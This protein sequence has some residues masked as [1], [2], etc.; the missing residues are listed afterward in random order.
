[1]AVC[2]DVDSAGLLHANATPVDSCPSY[3]LVDASTY[4]NLPTIQDLFAVPLAA[5]L[6]TLWMLGFGYPIIFYL[7][8]WAYQVVIDFATKDEGN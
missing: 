7:V 2:V 1:M 6:Q 8:A 5:D 3:V 4:T